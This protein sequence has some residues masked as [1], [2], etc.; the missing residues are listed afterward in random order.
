[1]EAGYLCLVQKSIRRAIEQK[2]FSV[3]VGENVIVLK[4]IKK[5]KRRSYWTKYEKYQM[6]L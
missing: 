4:N 5:I 1:M 3:S 6:N 2:V